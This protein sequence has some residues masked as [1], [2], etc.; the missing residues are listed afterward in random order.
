MPSLNFYLQIHEFYT[1][2]ILKQFLLCSLCYNL[3]EVNYKSEQEVRVH[4]TT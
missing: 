4:N 1:S 3:A 2:V